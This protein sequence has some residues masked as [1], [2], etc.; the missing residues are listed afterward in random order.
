LL[1]KRASVK[2]AETVATK[3][4]KDQPEKRENAAMEE[5]NR[6]ATMMAGAAY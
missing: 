1:K 6:E 2:Y 4:C 3:K 5:L